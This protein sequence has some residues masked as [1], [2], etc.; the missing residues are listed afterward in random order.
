MSV[1]AEAMENWGLLTFKESL[2]L[3]DLSNCSVEAKAEIALVVAHEVAHQWFGNI[4]TMVTS[5]GHLRR[6]A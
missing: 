1:L 5:F 3:V 6:E 2:V 4:V